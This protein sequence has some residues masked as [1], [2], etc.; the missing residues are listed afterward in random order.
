[1][2]AYDVKFS[3]NLKKPIPHIH[4]DLETFVLWILRSMLN[5]DLLLICRLI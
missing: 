5:L 1:M 3:R 2:K 4:T